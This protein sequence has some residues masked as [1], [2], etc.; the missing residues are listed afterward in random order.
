MNVN[1][2]NVTVDEALDAILRANG[3]R[4]T[5]EGNFI[6]VWTQKEYDGQQEIK[7]H[8][9]VFRLNYIRAAD[10][11]KMVRPMLTPGRGT[12]TISEDATTGLPSG[13]SDPGGDRWSLADTLIVI[14]LEEKV[15]EIGARIKDLDLRPKMCMVE[16]TILEASIN[17]TNALGIDF[18]ALGGINFGDF[19]HD[20]TGMYNGGLQAA[21]GPN[22]D[23]LS[24]PMN[25]PGADRWRYQATTSLSTNIPAG[26]I[27]IGL[28][29]NSTAI[30]IRAVESIT[31]TVVL[32]NPKVLALNKQSAEVVVGN[33]DGY[34]TTSVSESTTVQSVE[35]LETG[36][37]LIFRP[38]ISSD[39]YVR[40]EIH[41]E[42]SEGSV[43]VQGDF[44][45]PSEETTEITTNV[46]IK[47]GHTIV[48]GG[49]F[50]EETTI[51]RNQ[52]PFL[53][54]IPGLG[55]LFRGHKD[56]TQ[57][58]EL[59]FLITP[60]VIDDDDSEDELYRESSQQMYNVNNIRVGQRKGLLPWGRQPVAN[61][62]YRMANFYMRNDNVPMALFETSLAMNLYPKFLEARQLRDKILCRRSWEASDSSI[63]HF[64]RKRAERQWINRS[65]AYQ[66]GE[67]DLYPRTK[68]NRLDDR[69]MKI[70]LGIK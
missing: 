15:A 36:I 60:H 9:A 10:V 45:L 37:Q 42:K 6:Y 3:F 28:L 62:H 1:L 64:L 32:A 68:F 38:Y 5:K 22:L 43:T 19:D 67:A 29:H 18:N 54:N 34:I 39:G 7:L 2:H 12:I 48:I 20:S 8:S 35:F 44:A 57:R 40:M 23:A 33:R 70:K 30:F 58:K 26:G 4:Y 27:S 63:R 41:P 24:A 61:L 50:K 31:D 46:I 25:A 56:Q 65:P 47:D 16:A 11:A 59:I 14:D 51:S 17:D 52:I 49:L 55:L 66:D 69:D 53:G 13:P 21:H